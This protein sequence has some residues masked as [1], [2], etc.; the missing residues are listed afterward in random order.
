MYVYR[1]IQAPSSNHYCRGKAISITYSECVFGAL[2]IQ[3]A[4][5][6]HRIILSSVACLALPYFSTLSHKRHDFRNKVIEYKI[7]ILENKVEIRRNTT[8][9]HLFD[10]T[11]S[12]YVFMV[13]LSFAVFV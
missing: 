13:I 10:R 11:T 2:V 9:F 5:R 8:K 1:N 4:K 3:H 6:M 12:L 7:Y